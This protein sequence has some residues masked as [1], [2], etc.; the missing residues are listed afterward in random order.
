MNIPSPIY[1]AAQRLS[2]SMR[3][4]A[5][6]NAVPDY[7]AV[8]EYEDVLALVD[9]IRNNYIPPPPMKFSLLATR[10]LE[11]IKNDKVS[12]SPGELKEK[13]GVKDY[14]ETEFR[15][16]VWDLLSNDVLCLTNDRKLEINEG[17]R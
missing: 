10:I 3:H 8:K 5:C 9:W 14:T 1:N 11:V 2:V 17:Y 7:S 16:T 6:T 4:E 12:Q 15:D 13:L